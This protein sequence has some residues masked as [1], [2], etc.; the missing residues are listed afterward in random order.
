MS[1]LGQKLTFCEVRRMSAK[2]QKPTTVLK[3]YFGVELEGDV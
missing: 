3:L 1:D 2:C